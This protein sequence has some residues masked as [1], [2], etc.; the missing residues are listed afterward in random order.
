MLLPALVALPLVA[1]GCGDACED[2]Q[3]ICN[4][5]IDPNQKASCEA[6][7]DGDSQDLCEQNIESFENICQ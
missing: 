7:V 4:S 1:L 2:L 5:C 3:L 6:T